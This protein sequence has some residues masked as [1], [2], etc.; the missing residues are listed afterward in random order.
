MVS[1]VERAVENIDKAEAE[2][3]AAK[4]PGRVRFDFD[5]L[6]DQLRKM[7]KMGGI[8]SLM[9]MLPGIGKIKGKDG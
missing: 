2:K 7:K 1:L 8:G 6:L 9:G 3:M 4:S 5:D